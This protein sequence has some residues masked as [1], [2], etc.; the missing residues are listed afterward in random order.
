ARS[1][2][3]SGV[4]ARSP[5]LPERRR[6]CHRLRGSG[7]VGERGGGM[8]DFETAAGAIWASQRIT[9]DFTALCACGGRF[10]GTE[11]ELRARERMAG[12]L[13]EATGGTVRREPV[14][15]LGWDREP[16]RLTFADGTSV[17][18]CALGR[19]PAT[20]PGGLKAEVIDLGRGI[21]ADFALAA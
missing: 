10:A 21:P 14:P 19:S 9:E 4:G 18:V 6:A 13:A 12:R 20:P 17:A 7:T 11:S 1:R 8:G 5:S 15:Y 2:D 3:T 16:A